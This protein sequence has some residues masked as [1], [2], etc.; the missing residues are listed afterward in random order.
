MKTIIKCV[1]V[2]AL[3]ICI[4]CKQKKFTAT[5]EERKDYQAAYEFMKNIR[6]HLDKKEIEP[7]LKQNLI[8]AADDIVKAGDVDQ[9]E[10]EMTYDYFKRGLEKARSLKMTLMKDQAPLSKEDF[11]KYEKKYLDL[12]KKLNKLKSDHIKTNLDKLGLDETVKGA[13]IFIG[14]QIKKYDF[15][16]FLEK[17]IVAPSQMEASLKNVEEIADLTSEKILQLQMEALGSGNA[18]LK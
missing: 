11:E 17:T 2:F 1:G 12:Q 18:T 6:T 15:K 7:T 10:K 14:D 13:M 3:L 8:S 9:L 5:A 4:S 16:T